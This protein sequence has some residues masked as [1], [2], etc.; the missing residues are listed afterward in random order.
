[1][2]STPTGSAPAV[3]RRLLLLPLPLLLLLLAV[4]MPP[5]EGAQDVLNDFSDIRYLNCSLKLLPELQCYGRA[6]SSRMASF[7]GESIYRG[8][9]TC[10]APVVNVGEVEAVNSSTPVDQRPF[11]WLVSGGPSAP[12]LVRE[13]ATR[14]WGH[15]HASDAWLS[16]PGLYADGLSTRDFESVLGRPLPPRDKYRALLVRFL[17]L[18]R[19]MD[20]G[21]VAR[22]SSKYEVLTVTTEMR[23]MCLLP[24]CSD[25]SAVD[26]TGSGECDASGC[27]KD[28]RDD[29]IGTED[30]VMVVTH[31]AEDGVVRPVSAVQ[32]G[33]LGLGRAVMVLPGWLPSPTWQL[34][35]S[36]SSELDAYPGK[37]PPE[38]GGGN[39]SSTWPLNGGAR[40]TPGAATSDWLNKVAFLLC[41]EPV[42]EFIDK[43]RL[44]KG[45]SQLSPSDVVVKYDKKAYRKD[46]A[47]K[48]SL[49][50]SWTI[51]PARGEKSRVDCTNSPYMS[52]T[53]PSNASLVIE[54]MWL[55]GTASREIS[56]KS[57][58]EVALARR[59]GSCVHRVD[60]NDMWQRLRSTARANRRRVMYGIEDTLTSGRFSV[61][62]EPDESFH[63]SEVYVTA[64]LVALTAIGAASFAPN[65]PNWENAGDKARFAMTAVVGLGSIT[66]LGLLYWKERKGDRWIA[67]ATY[68]AINAAFSD[69]TWNCKDLPE[70]CSLSDVG[71]KGT[72]VLL[73]ETIAVVTTNGYRP[74]LLLCLICAAAVVYIFVVLIAYGAMLAR[75]GR[76]NS[77]ND[78]VV[79]KLE[80]ILASIA[81]A[82]LPHSWTDSAPVPAPP[83]KGQ[84]T[85][86]PYSVPPAHAPPRR[87]ATDCG[88]PSPAPAST[89]TPSPAP[90]LTVAA[91]PAPLG[92]TTTD[93]SGMRVV[94]TGTPAPPPPPPPTAQTTTDGGLPP[95][96]PPLRR[97]QTERPARRARTGWDVLASPA[98]PAHRSPWA[99][100]DGEG[101]RA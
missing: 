101:E 9:N 40:P 3:A 74:N 46:R 60:K 52:W 47:K 14:N 28:T 51:N 70:S 67:S 64:L 42:P 72:Y 53:L 63:R 93:C 12:R 24:N 4:T 20:G 65:D 62:D 39:G 26:T 43:K 11:D 27:V 48:K 69:T 19:N 99:R 56:Y 86:A 83:P 22:M 78:N 57:P 49:I 54:P 77:T 36:L 85:A 23:A 7:N 30:A 2:G 96:P 29:Q 50:M 6:N 91:S 90:A 16:E 88:L 98:A 59:L 25:L 66:S 21:E 17:S 81:T 97:S 80:R 55:A 8:T 58:E 73:S 94:A 100:P 95:L 13:L 71:M 41:Q 1:M 75:A 35:S 44:C 34:N 15:D 89:A 82:L 31:K 10:A 38:L 84:S 76:N 32:R 68:K 37:I 87:V 5:P 45:V 61:K 33:F 79:G 92:R 18:Q